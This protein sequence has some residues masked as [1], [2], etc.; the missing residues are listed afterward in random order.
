M[1]DGFT[2]PNY[3]QAPND[4]FDL[5]LPLMGYA[6]LKVSAVLIRWTFGYHRQR[7]ALSLKVLTRL[8]GLSETN[9][10]RGALA[11][12][13]RG[14]VRRLNRGAGDRRITR[15]EVIVT[16][17][18]VE[19]VGDAA[20]STV[21]VA[22]P[23]L[24]RQTTSTV[25]VHLNKDK[26][27]KNK[28]TTAPIAAAA[29]SVNE[30]WD[31][32]ILAAASKLPKARRVAIAKAN[33]S[34]GAYVA[35]YLYGLSKPGIDRP[36]FWAA[37]QCCENPGSWEGAPFD[38]LA[39]LG[40]AAVAH[41]LAWLR[42]DKQYPLNL[43]GDAG[44]ALAFAS[45]IQT[46]WAKQPG[47]MGAELAGAI[48]DLGLVHLAAAP[49]GSLDV[50][51]LEDERAAAPALAEPLALDEWQ[52]KIYAERR[53]LA[54]HVFDRLSRCTL[55]SA[56]GGRLQV[57]APNRQEFDWLSNRMG[58]ALAERYSATLVLREG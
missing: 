34:A 56:A 52:E 21:E 12:E 45:H 57:A 36:A 22:L 58:K 54:P 7:V 37:A 16:T 17:S 30:W 43:N 5:Y 9:V 19:V 26:Q 15:W 27:T 23:L 2:S 40:P 28:T 44:A 42:D 8:T 35:K 1:P 14:L 32:E 29:A 11:A 18:T 38:V 48:A 41:V 33:P 31:L 49:A 20:T 51:M 4:W 50:A 13:R 55:V 3:T 6:E 25:E 39:E 10:M 47:R 53:S 46:R 24:Q